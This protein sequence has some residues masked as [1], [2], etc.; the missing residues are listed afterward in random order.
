MAKTSSVSPLLGLFSG[1][2][3]IG[4]EAEA[5]IHLSKL[6]SAERLHGPGNG[7]RPSQFA[8]S[9]RFGAKRRDTPA[10][11]GLSW[12]DARVACGLRERRPGIGPGHRQ[13]HARARA[14]RICC[15]SA[16]DSGPLSGLWSK[17]QCGIPCKQW[18][19]V[20]IPFPCTGMWSNREAPSAQMR[21]RGVTY[22]SSVSHSLSHNAIYLRIAE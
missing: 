18:V 8:R 11:A 20:L 14:A 15:A 22:Q 10:P 13:V 1:G 6:H 4:S 9:L 21:I 5:G 3:P 2:S 17:Q 16:N 19:L 12:R 7:R